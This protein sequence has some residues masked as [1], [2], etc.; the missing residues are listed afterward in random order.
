MGTN[1]NPHVIPA[2][3]SIEVGPL[4]RHLVLEALQQKADEIAEGGRFEDKSY[5]DDD[6]CHHMRGGYWNADSG[7][8]ADGYGKGDVEDVV[9]ALRQQRIRVA[10]EDVD[11]FLGQLVRTGALEGAELIVMVGD[12]AITIRL[13]IDT[14][15]PPPAAPTEFRIRNML[16]VEQIPDVFVVRP[17]VGGTLTR[18]QAVMVRN[19]EPICTCKAA[20]CEHGEA[21]RE[22]RSKSDRLVSAQGLRLSDAEHT[23]VMRTILPLLATRGLYAPLERR[24]RGKQPRNK[25]QRA[26]QLILH[27]MLGSDY[28]AHPDIRTLVRLRVID[29]AAGSTTLER[30]RIEPVVISMLD[31]IRNIATRPIRARGIDA[32]P[33]NE[34]RGDRIAAEIVHALRLHARV[35]DLTTPNQ[36]T[37]KNAS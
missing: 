32:A 11:A 26:L 12:R 23:A 22:H 19:G 1:K 3:A 4:V 15:A 29:G 6:G 5:L 14:A 31:E 10:F 21:V 35:T 2:P 34:K 9:R 37:E 27:A 13:D 20:N 24:F 8:A 25:A 28:A 30:Y 17:V 36:R 18:T 7:R 16:L 33:H